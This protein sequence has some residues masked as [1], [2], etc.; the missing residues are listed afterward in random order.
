MDTWF[1]RPCSAEW[2]MDKK[3]HARMREELKGLNHKNVE[4]SNKMKVLENRCNSWSKEVEDSDET[5]FPLECNPK[6]GEKDARDKQHSDM[7]SI[8]EE[9][10]KFRQDNENF[11]DMIVSLENR[12]EK[13]EEEIIKKVMDKVAEHMGEIQEKEKKKNIIVF[14]VPESKKKETRERVADDVKKCEEVFPEALEVRDAKIERIYRIGKGNN[15]KA[16]PIIV[17][18]NEAEAKWKLVKRAKNL[19][20]ASHARIKQVIIAPDLTRKE[21]EENDKLREELKLRRQAGGKWIIRK[22][23]VIKLHDEPEKERDL[24]KKKINVNI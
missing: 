15:D 17:E 9:K 16:R 7:A 5:E 22:G 3:E 19:K 21:R 8:K 23:K 12:W 6:K 14:N 20:N 13:R 18:L 2:K 10:K 24:P 4:I 1:C 11:I